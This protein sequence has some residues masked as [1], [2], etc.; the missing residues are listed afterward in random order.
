MSK[1]CCGDLVVR[2]AILQDKY[3]VLLHEHQKLLNAYNELC[4]KHQ[5]KKLYDEFAWQGL[6]ETDPQKIEDINRGV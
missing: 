3:E 1:S 2:I 5:Y 4:A 6:V